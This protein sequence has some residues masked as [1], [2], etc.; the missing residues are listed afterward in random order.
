MP[1]HVGYLCLCGFHQSNA[2]PFVNNLTYAT[3]CFSF[4]FNVIVKKLSICRSHPSSSSCFPQNACG[5]GAF[6]AT[7]FSCCFWNCLY[8][9]GGDGL[10]LIIDRDS[11]GIGALGRAPAAA[12]PFS[13]EYTMS[14][15]WF[16][17]WACRLRRDRNLS[18]F[19]NRVS[20]FLCLYSMVLEMVF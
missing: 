16:R 5:V 17:E 18:I 9:S 1:S 13:T 14:C 8:S 2:S 19:S 20:Y 11:R 7:K 4:L 15:R 12:A 6:P 10:A 3:F